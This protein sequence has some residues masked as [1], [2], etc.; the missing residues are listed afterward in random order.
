[1]NGPTARSRGLVALAALG[2]VA[3]TGAALLLAPDAPSPDADAALSLPTWPTDA[4]PGFRADLFALPDDDLAGFVPI[5]AGSFLMGSDPAV[6]PMAFALEQWSPRDLQGRVELDAFYMARYEVTAA[7]FV[8]FVEATGHRRPDAAAPIGE[9]PL[10]PAANVSW[11]DALRYTRWL[12]TEL[13][14]SP[15]TPAPLRAL[16][17]DGWRVA[18]PDEAQWEKAARGAEGAIF[19]WGDE[20]DRQAANFATGAPE[21]VGQRSCACA[22][23]L[24][25]MAGNVWEWTASPYQPY[26]HMSSDDVRTARADALWIMRGGSF[27]DDAQQVRAANRG[28]AD[29]GARRPFIGFR[30]A[31]VRSAG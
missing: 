24:S 29:P 5:P 10:L 9:Q 12:D 13:R 4:I 19:P 8:A 21:P 2:L 16:L 22:H 6:D 7:Q 20:P 11:V 28:G 3:A 27:Q 31:L 1:M 15:A 14:S 17:D 23:G 26:P 25:D 30:V 18:L